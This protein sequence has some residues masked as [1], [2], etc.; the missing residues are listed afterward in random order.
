MLQQRATKAF[1]GSV[2]RISPAMKQSIQYINV[3]AIDSNHT[4]TITT[5]LD[6]GACSTV[7]DFSILEVIGMNEDKFLLSKG[8]LT[9]ASELVGFLQLTRRCHDH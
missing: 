3:E 4:H 5:T 2:R 6:Y 1:I 7:I 8:T 9:S